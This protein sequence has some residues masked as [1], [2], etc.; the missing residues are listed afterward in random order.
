MK[1]I[2]VVLTICR[3]LVGVLFVISG[4][5]KANDPL[6]FSYKLEEYFQVFS[7]D[8][9]FPGPI[10]V[11]LSMIICVFEIF[12]G[13]CLLIGVFR[14]FTAWMLLIM[15]IFFSFLTFYSA[16]FHKVTDCG[17]FGDAIHLKPWQSFGKDMILLVL[18]L[19]IFFNRRTIEPLFKDRPSRTVAFLAL[20][21]SIMF[22][23][24]AYYYLPPI[25]F[26]PYAVG[27]NIHL[28][29]F[30]PPGKDS[31]ITGYIYEDNVK[32]PVYK[33][34]SDSVLMKFIYKDKKT[35]KTLSLTMDQLSH[36]DSLSQ[37]NLS[38]NDTFIERKDDVIFE[39][40]KAPIHDFVITKHEKIADHDTDINVTNEFLAEKGYR[41]M[42]VQYNLEKS[43]LRFQSEL[44]KLVKTLMS[45]GK[46]KIWALTSS[47]GADAFRSLHKLP[48]TFYTA[49]ET[50]LKTITRSNPGLVL[51][52]NNVVI[53]KW[54]ATALP[55]AET[56]YSYM[57]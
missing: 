49:D 16:A 20:L 30:A 43:A 56:L 11:Y 6:G 37:V 29:M 53:K 19:P 17:C 21:A 13:V 26:R 48:Y 12:V 7:M 22:T 35:G 14:N 46:V 45:D 50:M 39:A 18:I 24:Y 47:S 55:D 57:K 42:I 33:P 9:F 10:P 1:L 4:F 2:K 3:V 38:K 52:R 15:I 28:Q 8:R 31:V 5:I 25:D 54:P 32:Y 44:N 34:G 51:L 41:L 36:M 40:P 27:K 23:I